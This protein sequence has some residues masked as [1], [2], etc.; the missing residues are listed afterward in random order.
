MLVMTTGRKVCVNRLSFR[1]DGQALV[2][3]TEAGVFLWSAIADGAKAR[4]LPS[5]SFIHDARFAGRWIVT[6]LYDLCRID[7]EPIELRHAPLWYSEETKFDVSPDGAHVV[8]AQP[9]RTDNV[10]HMRV[11]M[12]HTDAIGSK[13]PAWQ[14]DR[15][16]YDAYAPQFLPDGQRFVRVD[17]AGSR[18]NPRTALRVT[19]HDAETGAPLAEV[20]VATVAAYE[21]CIS[22][23]VRWLALRG[24]T[25]I[26]VSP[27]HPD[28][29]KACVLK[30]DGRKY[31]TGFAFHPNGRF[32]AATNNDNTVKLFDVTTGTEIRTFTW[33]LGRM[34]C[35]CFSA[36]G[37][38]AAAGSDKGQV[39]VW[40]VD[41]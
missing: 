18:V 20:V 39:V 8:V 34:R 27:L 33:Q 13:L 9:V 40:D 7:P 5:P 35:V 14:F 22:A 10:L 32:L 11:A 3:A 21:T 16:G 38:L 37:T 15:P 4:S 41:V 23:D 36:D 26:D 24:T 2:A 1:P 19:T 17:R 25:Q 12:W 30:S 31:F 28:Y 6:A 29:G